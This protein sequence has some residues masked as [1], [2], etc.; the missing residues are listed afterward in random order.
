MTIIQNCDIPDHTCFTAEPIRSLDGT[1]DGG[2]I[3]SYV[4]YVEDNALLNTTFGRVVDTGSGD[5]LMSGNEG[6]ELS[7]SYSDKRSVVR[8][9]LSVEPGSHRVGAF[10][11]K[12]VHLYDDPSYIPSI[13]LAREAYIK[14]EKRTQT[15]SFGET[16]TLNM[17]LVDG[18]VTDLRWRRNENIIKSWSGMVNVTIEE[19]KKADA[20]IYECYLKN[21]RNEGKHAIMRLIVRGCSAARWGPDCQ[22]VCPACY[23]GGVC[24]DVTGLCVCPPGFNTTDC[25]FG[26]GNNRWGRN[27]SIVCN[28]RNPGCLGKLACVPDPLGCSCMAGYGGL[29][30]KKGCDEM[31]KYG[32]TCSEECHCADGVVCDPSIGCPNGP[33]EDGYHGKNCQVPD[34]CPDGRYGK[35]CAY[36]CH[37]EDDEPCNRITGSCGERKCKHLWIGNDCQL[38]AP[39]GPK[40]IQAIISQNATNDIQGEI[41]VRFGIQTGGIII[42]YKVQIIDGDGHVIGNTI[43][44]G[45]SPATVTGGFPC[46]SVTP[47]VAACTSTGCGLF[48]SGPNITMNPAVPES[49]ENITVLESTLVWDR[50][51]TCD[52][53]KYHIQANLIEMDH[54]QQVDRNEY[55]TVEDAEVNLLILEPYSRY[56][57][58]IS[59]ETSAGLGP[60]SA[61]EF[62]TP[63]KVPKHGPKEVNVT[64]VSATA[65]SFA[66]S[67][68]ECG[69]RRGLVIGYKFSLQNADGHELFSNVVTSELQCVVD[70]LKPFTE[71]AFSV[72]AFN[73]KGDGISKVLH[74]TTDESSNIALSVPGYMLVGVGILCV[75]ILVMYPALIF[76]CRFYNSKKKNKTEH[77]K[78]IKLESLC[79]DSDY[80]E[81]HTYMSIEDIHNNLQ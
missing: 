20:G 23:N 55:F 24:D 17:T 69:Y 13:I 49:V 79:E 64:A 4:G 21:R 66:W 71:Y 61:L 41:D 80:E 58:T 28:S 22:N 12:S 32:S 65:A 43:T 59:A 52:I 39:A 3:G 25:S 5:D 33:C 35:L 34:I 81:L 54:C 68:V 10:F 30:C 47:Q 6:I 26:C 53:L 29:N 51:S 19:V 1:D 37:C 57:V 67:Q 36:Y 44:V 73:S 62:I 76:C 15:V 75:V 38:E 27:C 56:R 74:I 78:V 9:Y 48:A 50:P 70:D 18:N 77:S 8:Q 7:L 11:C 46:E 14:P 40:D 42:H 72:K 60:E 31:G 2:V 16:V 45:V 63:Q